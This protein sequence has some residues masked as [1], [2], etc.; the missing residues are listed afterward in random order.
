MFAMTMAMG[1]AVA[2]LV[3]MSAAAVVAA[4]GVPEGFTVHIHG[5]VVDRKHGDDFFFFY[6][7]FFDDATGH[8][9][10]FNVRGF[11]LGFRVDDHEAAEG[12]AAV[13]VAATIP[14]A[15]AA[16]VGLAATTR[17]V[18]AGATVAA[19]EVAVAMAEGVASLGVATFGMAAVVMS[20]EG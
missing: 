3:T 18:A 13:V 16:V 1:T 8:D 20:A 5:F 11:D 17:K 10:G 19:T 14:A 9:R 12:V 15:F 6:H 4:T 2:L 7:G